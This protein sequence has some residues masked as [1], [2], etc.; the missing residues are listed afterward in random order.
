[1]SSAVSVHCVDMS[2]VMSEADSS[3]PNK[4]NDGVVS[5]NYGMRQLPCRAFL[6]LA[7]L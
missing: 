1:M 5:G 7:T 2:K 3:D 4:S 6:R